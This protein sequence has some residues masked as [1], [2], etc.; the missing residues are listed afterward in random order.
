MSWPA[1]LLALLVCHAVGD[2]LLQTEWQALE[3]AR[4]LG[5]PTGRRALLRHV[6]TYTIAFLPALAFIGAQTSAARAVGI[7]AAV[8]VP[9]LLV[10]DGRAVRAWLRAVK[11]VDDPGPGLTV[12]VDQSFHVLFLLG[13][14]LLSA[15]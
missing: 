14:A 7:G 6:G 9:H 10:D 5:D 13:A 4:G 1:A 11:H 12:A 8:A 3:K 2:V 15:A